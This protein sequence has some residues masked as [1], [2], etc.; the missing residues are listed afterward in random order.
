PSG[1][2]VLPLLLGFAAALYLVPVASIGVNG[3]QFTMALFVGA[4]LTATS[5]AITAAVLFE[6]NLL[7]DRVAQTI[8]GAAVVDDVLGLV[9]LSVAVGT[10]AGRAGFVD[11]VIRVTVSVV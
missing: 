11:L 3:T 1:G 8:L 7:K 10:A 2:V 5:V 9:V 4:T 6:L